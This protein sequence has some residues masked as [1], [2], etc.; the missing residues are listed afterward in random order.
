M[1]KHD[2]NKVVFHSKQDMSG[3]YYLSKGEAILKSEFK[4][5]PNNINDVLELYNIKLYI[6]NEVY[7]KK[8]SLTEIET[9]RER[10]R[11][12]GSYVGVF[13]SKIS[14]ENVLSYHEELI[15][16]Y[17]DTFWLL[18]N[19]QKVFKNIS[20]N[21]IEIIL[22]KKPNQIRTILKHKG[23]VD[24]YNYVLRDFL[25]SYQQSAEI[26]LSIYE[27]EKG[28]NHVELHL[29]K[30]LTKNEKEHII[31]KYIDSNEVNTN[32]LTI[33]QNSKK[34]TDF[35]I[36]DK[37]RLKAR[38]KYK[39][40]T[41]KY[42]GENS[43]SCLM[44]YGV[45]ICYPENV[46][47][48][49]KC[50]LENSIVHYEYS[51][52][53]IRQNQHPYLL[54]LNFKH[55]FEYLDHQ[56]RINLI[57]KPSQLGVMERF[58]GIRSKNEYLCGIS[59]NVNEM[60]S[61]AQVFTYSNVLKTLDIS[62]E[63]VLKF[64][65]T[66]LLPDKYGFASNANL[67]MPTQISSALEK[68]RSLAPELESVLK[69]YK[70]FVEENEIDFELLQMSSSPSSIKDIP[71]LNEN[72]YVYINKSNQEAVSCSNLFFSDQTLLAYVE[73]FIEKKYQT[74]F[75][76]LQNES[77]I[78]LHN[79]E[80]HQI[81]DI[82]Y[83]IEKMYLFIDED[84]CI[85]LTNDY[86]VFILKDLYDNEFSSFY[87][88]P[89]E[90]QKEAIKMNEEGLIS[91]DSSLLSK[92]E[93]DYFNYYL[94][95]SEFTNGLDLRNSYLH[96]TQANPSETNIHENCYLIYLKLLTLILMKIE[97]DLYIHKLRI[98]D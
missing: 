68:V 45:D 40:E 31:S 96:G 30:S 8:W 64:I 91:F 29:P 83:L 20:C 47:K 53:Y 23:L 32:Y 81:N 24:R 36:S 42:F 95:K 92:P 14:D 63:E 25:L 90:A 88:Y 74:L 67:T 77:N 58:M 5:K 78:Y 73:P 85:Q 59:F 26:L 50:K 61:Q 18:I 6:D 79:Y 38:R 4:L 15:F 71:S 60:A 51:L 2:R 3:G 87:H 62:L 12:Y 34:H 97:D 46:S 27:V 98:K 10:V 16:E 22:N 69:Q 39:E 17:I 19:N 66:S 35:R 7:L 82:K 72:K 70:L 56:N 33:I 80:D 1:H 89:D 94:N 76:L 54:Y 49:K 43:K 57:S 84:D 28:F 86:R 65:Y 41:N 44:K 52:D 37:T 48:I 75:E 13:I 21:K 11:E 93:Q 9:F 55:L